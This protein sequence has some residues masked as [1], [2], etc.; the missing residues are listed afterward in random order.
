MEQRGREIGDGRR[1]L[2]GDGLDIGAD[3]EGEKDPVKDGNGQ[4]T[5]AAEMLETLLISPHE[6]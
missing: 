6:C 1:R 3:Q 5:E 4:E 2:V